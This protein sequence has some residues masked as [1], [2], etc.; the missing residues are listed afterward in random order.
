MSLTRK[1]YGQTLPETC[2]GCGKQRTIVRTWHDMNEPLL[3]QPFY[4]NMPVVRCTECNHIYLD[5]RIELLK[6]TYNE[7][8]EDLRT[9]SELNHLTKH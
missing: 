4:M 5:K 7:W 2:V 1:N 9:R 6:R 8:A 3:G